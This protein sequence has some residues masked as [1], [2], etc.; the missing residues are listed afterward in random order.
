[1]EAAVLVDA[2]AVVEGEDVLEG[3]DVALHADDLGD[4]GDAA[5]AVLQPRLVDDQ[6]DGRGDLLADGPHRD[7]DPGHQDHG[8]QPRQHVAGRVGVDGGQRAVVAGVHGLEHVEGLAAPD[9][10]DHDP[11]GAHPQGVA[12]QVADGDLAPALDVGRAVLEAQAG[13]L[14]PR[15]RGRGVEPRPGPGCWAG[16]SRGAAS[17]AGPAGA[18]PR[19]QWWRCA[20]QTAARTRA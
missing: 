14:A 9:L 4:M 19:P 3:D 20:R 15:G 8:L 17:V 2:G 11:V 16:G 6:V 13:W 7:V 18:R 12:D 10:A 5:G 1:P